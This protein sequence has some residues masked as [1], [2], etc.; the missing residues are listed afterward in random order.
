MSPLILVLATLLATQDRDDPET[1]RRAFTVAE[2]FEVNLFAS[3]KEGVVKPLQIRWDPQGRLWVSCGPS[4]PQLRPGEEADDSILVLEDKDGDGRADASRVFAKGLSTPMG[5]EVGRGGVFV[6]SGGELLH[7]KDTGSDRPPERTV[8]LRGF[9]SGDSHQYINSFVWGP[10]GDLF[11]CQGLHAVARV[12]TPWGVEKLEKAGFW[13]LRDR[14]LKLDP[15]LGYDMG[16]QN[17][18]GIVFDDWG[19][20]IMVS[21]N[22]QGVYYPVPTMIRTTHFLQIAQI[23]DKT[24]KLAG[25]DYLGGAHWPE[26]LQ[27]VL[28]SGAYLNNSFY[29][30]RI[31]EDGAGFRAKNL[32]PIIVS[33]H[34]SFRPVDVRVGPDGAIY[35]ADWYNPIIGHYQA[36]FRHPDRDKTHGR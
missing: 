16:P 6:G 36:S 17:P 31:T 4:Y 27:G 30:F 20:P 23:W 35:V 34:S 28:V 3:E 14:S 9:F 32:P 26:E 5:L 29:A 25:A 1:E 12:E 11:F 19:Q 21:G 2:G 18:Y 7:L 8:V 10:G 33:S 24:N 13:R 22:G 15:F